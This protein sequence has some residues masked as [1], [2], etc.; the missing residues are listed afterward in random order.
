[1]SKVFRRPMFRKGGGANMNGIMS[2]IQDRQNYQD[3]GRVGEL[4]KQNLDLLMQVD[5][6]WETLV[7]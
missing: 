3:A 4:T 5:R 7:F 2:G 6:D 1:M